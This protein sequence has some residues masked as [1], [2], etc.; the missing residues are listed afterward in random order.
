MR[1]R[2]LGLTRDGCGGRTAEDLEI[3]HGGV[4]EENAEIL[5]ALGHSLQDLDCDVALVRIVPDWKLF[6]E[7]H[8]TNSV[9][10]IAL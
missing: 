7:I 9:Q 8:D 6:T 2:D 3:H 5:C 4:D 1:T 10:K